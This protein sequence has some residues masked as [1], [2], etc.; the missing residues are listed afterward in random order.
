MDTAKEQAP[1]RRMR[2]DPVEIVA[3]VSEQD[4]QQRALEVWLYKAAK[5]GWS[6]T[7]ES[8]SLDQPGEESAVVDVEGLKYRIRH[9]K[10]IRTT[11]TIVP[12]GQF[13]LETALLAT[14]KSDGRTRSY[15]DF[16]HAAWAEPILEEV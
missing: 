5:A 12:T 15:P 7:V 8:S 3:H 10:R 16:T 13:G 4:G 6:V 1:A 11:V 14:G 9:P 2:T